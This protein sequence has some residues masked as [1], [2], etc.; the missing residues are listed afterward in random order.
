MRYPKILIISEFSFNPNSGTGLLFKNLFDGYPKERIGLIHED[1][2]FHDSSL[3]LSI[4][5]KNKNKFF[6]ILIKL[7]PN[8]IKHFFKKIIFFLEKLYQKRN[9]QKLLFAIKIILKNLILTL[10]IQ[11]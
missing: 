7:L 9:I 2:T 10:F 1:I 4:C 8:K 11:F 3:G 5:L 6:N